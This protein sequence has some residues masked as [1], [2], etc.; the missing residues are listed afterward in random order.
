MDIPQEYL[1]TVTLFD[2]IFP[3]LAEHNQLTEFIKSQRIKS[4][5]EQDTTIKFTSLLSGNYH[6]RRE[7]L[8]TGNYTKA[9]LNSYLLSVNVFKNE[10]IFAL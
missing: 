10:C 1:F 4:V 6:D 3:K 9:E 7:A 5:S 2:K 8:E